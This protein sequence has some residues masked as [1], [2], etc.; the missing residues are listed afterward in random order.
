MVFLFPVAAMVGYLC[1]PTHL[2]GYNFRY[3]FPLLPVLLVLAAFGLG[4]LAELPGGRVA[5][6]L[7]AGLTAAL[8]VRL[9]AHRSSP[10][11]T[12]GTPSLTA[13]IRTTPRRR[14]GRMTF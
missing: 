9:P 12:K 13:T 5:F 10:G 6:V 11:S 8:S 4:R 1:I 2:V 7:M 3:L 14:C